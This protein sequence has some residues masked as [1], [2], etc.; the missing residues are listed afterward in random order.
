MKKANRGTLRRGYNQIIKCRCCGH[1]TQSQIGSGTDLCQECYDFGGEF[2][3]WQ[4]GA[5]KAVDLPTPVRCERCKQDR[6]EAIAKDAEK[7]ARNDV[8]AP[9]PE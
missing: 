8:W 7:A 6:A 9:Q 2:N 5:C 1:K 3:T 4:D